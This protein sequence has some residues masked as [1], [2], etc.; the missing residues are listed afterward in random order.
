MRLWIPGRV[1]TLNQGLSLARRAGWLSGQAGYGPARTD[2]RDL[3]ANRAREEMERIKLHAFVG[4]YRPE[5][6]PL[7]PS[8]VV[9][10]I[11]HTRADSDGAALAAKWAIDA[12]IG[13]RKDH[14]VRSVTLQSIGRFEE[15]AYR[16]RGEEGPGF[17]FEVR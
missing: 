10:L 11:G 6:V 4:G 2:G 9:Q 14:G 3:L 1:L 5:R 13:N 12:L 16:A 7:A 15:P 17:V 8:V